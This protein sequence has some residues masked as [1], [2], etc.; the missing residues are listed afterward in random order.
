MILF[1]KKKKKT[2]KLIFIVFISITVSFSRPASM[3]S[4]QLMLYELMKDQQLSG[5]IV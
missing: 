4:S 1:L 5:E 3:A 2:L